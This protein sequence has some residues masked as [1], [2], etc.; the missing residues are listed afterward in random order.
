MSILLKVIL[1]S[2]LPKQEYKF[3]SCPK[4]IL[5]WKQAQ[6]TIGDQIYIFLEISVAELR[7]EL[8]AECRAETTGGIPL[9]YTLV[10]TLVYTRAYT[11]A[12]S[13]VITLQLRGNLHLTK[14]APNL[15]RICRNRKN[16]AKKIY[17]KT[18]NNH[19]QTPDA[20]FRMQQN[21]GSSMM[22][23]DETKTASKTINNN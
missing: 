14:F 8:P 22:V 4:C 5:A 23:I 17:K 12:M 9:A 21:P 13:L 18:L 16:D 3:M 1:I 11:R 6:N 7:A 10:Y 20:S 15:H 19:I 2:F